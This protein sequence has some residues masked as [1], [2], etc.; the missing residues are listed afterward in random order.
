[1]DGNDKWISA[2]KR[3][4]KLAIRF[5]VQGQQF[6]IA[7]GLKDSPRNRELVRIKR[8]QIMADIALERFDP[9]LKSYEFR[10]DKYSS[11]KLVDLQQ[12]NKYKYDLVQLWEK[13]TTYKAAL[14]EQTTILVRYRA[15]ARYIHKLPTHSLDEA[16]QIR[17]WLLGNTTHTM[18]WENLMMYSHCCDWAVNSGLISDNP[19]IRLKIPKPKKSEDDYRAFT[20]EQ[21]DLIIAAFEV[22][23]VHS[24][25]APL[26]KFL[27]W[28]GCRLG[29]AFAL[30]WGDVQANCTRI[31][32]NKSCNLYHINKGTKNNKRRVF[33]TAGDSRLQQLL[34]SIRP[35]SPPP[36]QLVFTSKLGK[37]LSSDIIQNF[38]NGVSNKQNNKTYFYPGVVREL[39]T[40]SKCPYLKPYATRHTFAT[41]AI[42][43]GVSPDKVALWIGD[44]VQTVLQ[45]YCHPNVVDSEC[46]D[47]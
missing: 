42:T 47:F 21:R 31:H 27:F 29:E 46:P 2:D 33:P 26:V 32:F 14:L 9:T 19:F 10:V 40:Q 18:A 20:L 38:W 7:S 1:M 43:S 24:H 28:T 5:R 6:F 36:N 37:P 17:D 12:E 13:F 3:T 11:T 22:H 15:I 30:T 25:Y 23:R 4:D 41:W 39:A 44:K 35:Q 34:I 45:H 16:A 8:D